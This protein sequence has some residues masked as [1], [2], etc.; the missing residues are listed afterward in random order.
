MFCTNDKMALMVIMTSK[1]L[2]IGTLCEH[3]CDLHTS[4]MK[5]LMN[6][7]SEVLII[8]VFNY[9]LFNDW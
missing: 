6:G 9:L 1:W 8:L 5:I 2:S 3:S 4:S 7:S